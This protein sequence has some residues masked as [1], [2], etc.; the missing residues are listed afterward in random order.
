MVALWRR[1][2]AKKT[3]RTVSEVEEILNERVLEEILEKVKNGGL[4]KGHVRELLE[5]VLK[6][7]K[8][9]DVKIEKAND[10]ELEEKIRKIVKGKSG[11]SVKGYMGLVM[12]EI[13]GVDA[14][15]AMEI[16]NRLVGS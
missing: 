15:K 9:M 5:E 10:N 6:G 11:L 14:R 16:L 1:D 4:E 12:K 2:F 3:G 13:K 7:K 8:V